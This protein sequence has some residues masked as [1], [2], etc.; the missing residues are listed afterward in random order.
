MRMRNIKVGML[1]TPSRSLRSRTK[2]WC[3]ELDYTGK[4]LSFANSFCVDVEWFPTKNENGDVF[5]G[6]ID[7][8]YPLDIEP[9]K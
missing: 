6:A 9:R 1:V 4:I 5:N 3:K 8:M 7:I 2:Y